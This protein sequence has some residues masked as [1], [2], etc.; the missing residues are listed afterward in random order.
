MEQGGHLGLLVP[1][2]WARLPPKH[3]ERSRADLQA[4]AH[5][6]RPVSDRQRDSVALI[7]EK[8]AKESSRRSMYL[9]LFVEFGLRL[10]A[11]TIVGAS[12]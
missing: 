7:G 9:A 8:S 11:M 3:C 6:T 12:T 10:H 2:L 5:V 4:Y 1:R